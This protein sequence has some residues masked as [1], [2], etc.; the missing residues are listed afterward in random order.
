MELQPIEKI[1]G[2]SSEDFLTNYLKKSIPVILDDFIDKKSPAL[3][4]WSYDYFK[5]IAGN[6]QVNVYGREEE[7]M[8][9]VASAPVDKMSFSE[10]LDLIEKEPTE[11]RLFLFNLMV[12]KPE[13]EKDVIY[14]DVTGGKVLKWLP[15]M[16]FGGEGSSTRNHIDIDM[17]HVF[18]SQFKG[19]KRIWL[20]PPSQSSL[21][22]RLPYNYHSL[23]N[24]KTCNP[25]EYSSMKYLK[26]Y[27][28]VIH[29][30]ETLYMPA[31]WWHFIQYET[32]G[33]SVSVRALPFSTKEK[34]KGFSNVV[35]TRNFDNAMRRLLKKRW[36]DYKVSVA[37]KRAQKA[38]KRIA[39]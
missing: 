29:P 19:A 34:I 23:I 11:L 33:F 30:G 32:E 20:F 31:G 14:N 17:S 8:E 28:A 10:Y 4:K 13:L 2:V 3:Q 7:S 26:G 37:R 39:G 18:I 6:H 38:L 16:F 9:R 5:K 25:K 21:L 15:L 12:I 36:F 35:I 24:L 22:Y 27:E 1:S